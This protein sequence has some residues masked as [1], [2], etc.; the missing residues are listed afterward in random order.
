MFIYCKYLCKL[1]SITCVIQSWMFRERRGRMA[2]GIMCCISYSCLPHNDQWSNL[3]VTTQSP[4]SD[5]CD[6]SMTVQ[7]CTKR[8]LLH[9]FIIVVIQIFCYYI[10]LPVLAIFVKEGEA[11]P[12]NT[13]VGT[14][15]GS[16]PDGDTVYFNILANSNPNFQIDVG[17]NVVRY[18]GSNLLDYETPPK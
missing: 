4:L 6:R 5:L 1:T 16:D 8:V 15:N 12:N 7:Y 17:T 13:V 14:V 3:S 2:S 11:T 10:L 9:F 18:L